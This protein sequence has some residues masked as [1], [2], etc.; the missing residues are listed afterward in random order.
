[1]LEDTTSKV[2]VSHGVVCWQMEHREDVS[3]A[4][5][6]GSIGQMRRKRGVG[7]LPRTM[8][9]S[10]AVSRRYNAHHKKC[11]VRIIGPLLINYRRLCK[12]VGI[13]DL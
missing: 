9:N 5:P 10:G 7:R 2:F 4:A 11:V 12:E 8:V 3:Q 13:I 1:M 6:R